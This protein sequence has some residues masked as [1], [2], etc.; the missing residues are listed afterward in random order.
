MLNIGEHLGL[1][2]LGLEKALLLEGVTV[3]PR[4]RP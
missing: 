1:L 3:I 2:Q 4:Q